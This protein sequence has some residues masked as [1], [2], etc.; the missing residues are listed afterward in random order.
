MPRLSERTSRIDPVN[1]RQ[2]LGISQERMSTLVRVSSKTINRWEKGE[3]KPNDPDSLSR[4]AK[5]KE[6]LE[7]GQMVYTKE[8]LKEFLSTPMPVFS[9]KSGFDLIQIGDY[10]SV[11]A[12]M[13]ADFEGTGF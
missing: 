13:A 3:S 6:I 11:I 8:G 10:E 2:G 9:G 5:L 1:I 4:L 7:L 12:A